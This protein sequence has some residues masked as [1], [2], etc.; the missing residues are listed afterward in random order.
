[1]IDPRIRYAHKTFYRIPFLVPCWGTEEFAVLRAGLLHGDSAHAGAKEE[2]ERVLAERF[3]FHHVVLTASG[4][5]A[6]EVALRST[7]NDPGGEVIIPAF[8]CRAVAN[9]VVAAGYVPVLADINDDLTVSYESIAA[10]ITPRTFAVVVPHLSGKPARDFDEILQLGKRLGL[11]VIDDAAQALGVKWE[12]SYLG[13]WGEFGVVSFGLGK[14]TFSLGGGALVVRSLEQ[15][16]R[17]EK[18]LRQEMSQR[19]TRVAQAVRSL[20][21][22][23]KYHYRRHTSPLYL[24]GRAIGRLRRAR[25]RAWLRRGISPLEAALQ[26]AQLRHLDAMAAQRV[27]NAEYLRRKLSDIE[28]LSVP[29]YSAACGYTKFIVSTNRGA[30]RELATHLLKHRVEIEWSY[31]PLGSLEEYRRYETRDTPVAKA[32]WNTLLTL[33]T[34]ARLDERDMEYVS[35]VVHDYF[36]PKGGRGAC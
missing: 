17:C 7:G 31:T 32:I 28:G 21:F 20:N 27:G 8:C 25:P 36:G 12:G 33:P 24:T 23:L 13:S 9:S 10:N 26:V 18:L 6:I 3:G 2:L 4:R 14:P 16:I 19:D 35:S 30:A 1:M 11:C 5:C 15:K 29:Q 34:H 22:V